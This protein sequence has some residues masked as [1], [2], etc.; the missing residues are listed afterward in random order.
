VAAAVA[1]LTFCGIC[2]GTG[3]GFG[4]T[5]WLD[6]MGAANTPAPFALVPK[7]VGY[8]LKLGGADPTAFL[9]VCGMATTALLAVI[10]GV[11]LVHF[12]DRPM[13]ALAWGTLALAVG[14]QALHPWYLP[15]SLVLLGLIPLTRTQ[16]R[17]SY[18][19]AIAFVLWNTLQ[20]VIWHGQQIP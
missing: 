2:V 3:L 13:A 15:W 5:R 16:R 9:A 17:F 8:F 1:V 11:I 4:W 12:A 20:T 6:L 14:G 19:L 18:G 10:L 7:V